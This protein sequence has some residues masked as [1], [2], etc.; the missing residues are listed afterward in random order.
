MEM[1]EA[2][3]AEHRGT[4]S[5]WRLVEP[6]LAE[7][8]YA[9]LG[10][11][12]AAIFGSFNPFLA[13]HDMIYLKESDQL[14]GVQAYLVGL[15]FALAASPCSTPVLATLLAYL[16]SSK[17]EHQGQ[18]CLHATMDQIEEAAKI[19]HAHTF[20]SS[21]ERG[22]QTQVGRAGLAL[23][24]EQKIKLSVARAVISSPS[25]LLLDEVTGGL[26]FEAKR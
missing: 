25:I 8:L 15:T 12:G 16:A 9:V 19:A 24:E 14:L 22:Y 20:I 6:S 21:L 18:Y 26:D 2:K 13:Y 17:A 4:P 10:N 11:I 3:D 23:T 1:K 5:F 7:W